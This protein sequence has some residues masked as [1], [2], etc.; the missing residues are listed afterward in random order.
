MK[1]RKINIF[2]LVLAGILTVGTLSACGQPASETTPP[3]A[4]SPSADAPAEDAPTDEA[5][6]EEAPS[7]EAPV[8]EAPA[9]G[10]EATGTIIVA[11]E[12]ETPSLTTAEHN[13]VAGDYMNDLTH[14]GLFKVDYAT[15]EPVPDLVESYKA[16][17]DTE[18]EFKLRENIVFHNGE[19]MTAADVVATLDYVKQFPD[20]AQYTKNITN[21]AVVDDYTFTITTEKPYAMLLNDLTHHSN[22]ILPK[23]LIDSGNDF[24]AN[25]IG[26]GPY[27][28]TDWTYGDS[29]SFTAV[30]NYYIPE[31]A[32]KIKDMTW[33][34]IPEGSSRTIALEAGEVDLVVE[35]A[36]QDI[37]RMQEN[38]D[39]T[40]H[41][42][43][44][45]SHN[46]MMVNNELPLFSD[47]NVRRALDM[48]I[49][50][51]D[52]IAVALD[53]LATPIYSQVPLGFVGV[54]EEGMNSYDPEGAKALLEAAGIDPASITFA[55]IC[56]NDQKKRCGE[57]IQANL[58]EI[59]INVTLESTDLTTYLEVTRIG[60]YEAAIGGF[61]SSDLL[62]YVSGVW[63]SASIDGSNKTRTNNP[64]IDALID[65][66]LV[67]T[68]A[69]EREKVL[70]ECTKVINEVCGQVPIYQDTNKR[71][72]KS[73]LIVPEL[74]SSGD[75]NLNMA[76]WA[77]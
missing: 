39:F 76:Y 19:P 6:S 11:T 32:P 40:V 14:S 38:P 33:R 2:S 27:M 28:F 52:V 43:P 34:I 10:T 47:V 42:G 55:I 16:N 57:V 50:K 63:H 17:T 68:D 44:G 74:A 72:F 69:A 75:L 70:L 37:P 9:V 23:S 77:E 41:I 53:G 36:T 30:D 54:S 21:P 4:E 60:D 64:E 58:A 7:E 67:T 46:F 22:F 13:A 24:N 71:M 12:N 26:S 20:A 49:N 25:P 66:A 29:V 65:K 15:L 8:A 45:T 61:T 35:V 56:S 48:S 59:G 73:N 1:N 5:P 51:E 31:R 62:G 3:A 18:W